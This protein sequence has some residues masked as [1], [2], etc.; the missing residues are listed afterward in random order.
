VNRGGNLKVVSLVCIMVLLVVVCVGTPSMLKWT[1]S[2][3]EVADTRWNLTSESFLTEET[4]P[5]TEPVIS[6]E[7]EDELGR[8]SYPDVLRVFIIL[9]SQPQLEDAARIKER[10]RLDAENAVLGTL[11]DSQSYAE[12]MDCETARMRKNLYENALRL[13]QSSQ[14]QIIDLVNSLG[15]R[16]LHR[17]GFINSIAAELAPEAIQILKDDPNVKR[18]ELSKPEPVCLDYSVPTT[19]AQYWYDMG[20]DGTGVDVLVLDSGVDVSHPGLASRVIDSKNFVNADPND[21]DDPHGHGTHVAGIIANTNSKFTGVAPGANILNARV[22]Y[23]WNGNGIPSI[24]PDHAMAG[25]EWAVSEAADDAEIINLSAGT[26]KYLVRCIDAFVSY[27]NVIWV[28]AAGNDGPGVA[29]I[30]DVGYNSIIVGSMEDRNT[31][32]RL[33]DVLSSFSSRGPTEDDRLGIDIVAPGG[34]IWSTP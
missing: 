2:T 24:Y 34:D 25:A 28:C 16:V 30:G 27:Y 20:Y 26:G 7:L 15:G 29:T 10:A 1:G 18:I 33:D 31:V 32:S 13:T 23:D 22:A 3:S 21:Y 6:S 11:E 5:E 4:T 14:D 12:I 9:E 8:S 19:R 17:Y